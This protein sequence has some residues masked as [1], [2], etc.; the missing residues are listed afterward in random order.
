MARRA[1]VVFPGLPHHVTQRGNR[2]QDVFRDVDDRLRFVELLADRTARAGLRIWAYTLMTNHVHLIVVP[3]EKESLANA[4]RDCLSDYARCFNVRAGWTGHLWQNRFYSSVLGPDH[5]WN[6]V[7][8]VERN[9]V[10][11]RLV[12][13]AEDYPW[14]SAAYHCGVR[15]TDPLLSP[16]SPLVGAREDW[17]GWLKEFND[18]ADDELLRRNT[19]TGMPSGCD[20]FIRRLEREL[21]RSIA[22]QQRGP[23]RAQGRV[24]R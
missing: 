10:R 8:Y 23:D 1:R 2:R 3:E 14:S 24:R 15:V 21:G 4:M 18:E 19:R 11:A 22:P 9:P 6:A 17:S 16:E 12:Q 7:R 20:A 13:R 5:L